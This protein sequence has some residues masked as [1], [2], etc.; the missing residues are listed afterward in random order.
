ML[1][2]GGSFSFG[3]SGTSYLAKSSQLNSDSPFGDGADVRDVSS[4]RALVMRLR[5]SE[6][7]DSVTGEGGE[8]MLAEGGSIFQVFKGLFVSF[9]LH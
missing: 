1:L 9:L 5:I 4:L 6:R 7:L 2:G 3:E 8:D